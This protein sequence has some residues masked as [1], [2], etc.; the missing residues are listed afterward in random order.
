MQINEKRIRKGSIVTV[1]LNNTYLIRY[2]FTYAGY[3][4]TNFKMLSATPRHV[5]IG[6][7]YYSKRNELNARFNNDSNKVICVTY[8]DNK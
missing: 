5:C 1:M 2:Q 8:G 6:S 4:H 3:K 7:G